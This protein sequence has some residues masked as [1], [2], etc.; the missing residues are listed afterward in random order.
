METRRTFDGFITKV[1]KGAQIERDL[2]EIAQWVNQLP[3]YLLGRMKP[4]QEEVR[5][6][7]EPGASR[8]YVAA[9]LAC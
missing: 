5:S 4:F 3:T 1:D 2:D 8:I 9:A 7:T 6:R